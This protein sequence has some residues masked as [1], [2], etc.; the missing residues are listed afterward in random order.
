MS[1]WGCFYRAETEEWDQKVW[2]I[3]SQFGVGKPCST[4]YFQEVGVGVSF[5][6]ATKELLRVKKI[7]KS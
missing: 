3:F 7:P 6:V 5:K 2:N 4:T 1:F